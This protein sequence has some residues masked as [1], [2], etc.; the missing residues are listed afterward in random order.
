LILRNLGLGFWFVN[1]MVGY[2]ES[3]M[4]FRTSMVRELNGS[5]IWFGNSMVRGPRIRHLVQ[6]LNKW[7][8]TQRVRALVGDL[9]ALG[10]REL[11]LWLGT[12]MVWV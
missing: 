8:G 12:S 1:S 7:F 6:E 2:V 5:G 11:G 9:N 4:W 10:P 3:G